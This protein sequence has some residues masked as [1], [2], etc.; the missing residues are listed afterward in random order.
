MKISHIGHSVVNAPGCKLL[1]NN[2]LYVP[3][4]YKN[5]AFVYRLTKDNDVFLEIHSGLF[6]INDEVSRRI[7]SHR[8]L[9]P[10]PGASVIK[11]ILGV[12]IP[13]LEQWHDRLGHPAYSVVAK[14]I[15]H[16]NLLVLEMSNKQLVCN[17]FQQAKSHQLPYFISHSNSQFPLELVFSDV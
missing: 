5:L 2:I 16:F 4:A 8:G 17:A 10:V 3:K 6:L 7:R 15:S 9:Y 13:S 1:L 11:Q 14:V 12:F